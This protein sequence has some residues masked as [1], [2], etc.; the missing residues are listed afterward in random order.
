MDSAE[1]KNLAKRMEERIDHLLVGMT[2]ILREQGFAGFEVVS[3]SVGE[4][5]DGEPSLFR[6][7][8]DGTPCPVRCDVMP[9]GSVKCEPKCQ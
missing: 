4:S 7:M 9:D 6:A 1:K 3:F 2:A 5:S 8:A